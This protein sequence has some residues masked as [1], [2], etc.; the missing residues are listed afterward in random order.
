M[1]GSDNIPLISILAYEVIAAAIG[2][3]TLGKLSF[4]K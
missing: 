3:E 4:T 2:I 1:L